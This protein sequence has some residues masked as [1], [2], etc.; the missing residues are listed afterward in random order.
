MEKINYVILDKPRQAKQIGG[1][2]NYQ[3]FIA[4]KNKPTDDQPESIAASINKEC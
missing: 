1:A 3:A 4:N 2:K